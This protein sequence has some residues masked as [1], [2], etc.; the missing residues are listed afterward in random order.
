M[1]QSFVS[2]RAA[3]G[4]LGAGSALAFV[5]C[6]SNVGSVK[7]L[8]TDATASY[9]S[10]FSGEAK[11]DE[12]DTSAGEYRKATRTERAKNVPKPIKPKNADENSVAGLYSSIAF[13]TAATQY[14]M[15]SGDD[16]LIEQTALND[17]E[18]KVTANL[19]TPKPKESGGEYTWPSR[20]TIGLGSFIATSGRDADVSSSS[21]S[22]TLDVDITGKYE[23]GHWVI[24]GFAAA[25]RSQVG[26]GSS[27]SSG[28]SI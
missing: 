21:R 17:T 1:T 11:I 10:D 5:G 23:N 22:T 3:L 18:P 26:S 8:P 16:S 13:Y 27:S 15:E 4:V 28:S 7:P 12:Y 14:M 20:F 9:R 2:R 6:A 24:G 25:F 19:T